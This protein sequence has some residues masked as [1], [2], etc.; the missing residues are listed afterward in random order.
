MIV[1]SSK[2]GF[3]LILSRDE[4]PGIRRFK[5]DFPTNPQIKRPWLVRIEDVIHG[6]VG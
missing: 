6:V 4:E 3:R 2:H 1:T 5:I